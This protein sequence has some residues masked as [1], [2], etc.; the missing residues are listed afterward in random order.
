MTPRFLTKV[1]T[2]TYIPGSK[3]GRL[4]LNHKHLSENESSR[5]R[6]DFIDT[7]FFPLK[8]LQYLTKINQVPACAHCNIVIDTYLSKKKKLA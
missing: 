5:S 6:I 3:H 8:N 2:M 1:N 7:V 4:I